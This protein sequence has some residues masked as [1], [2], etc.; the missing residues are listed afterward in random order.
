MAKKLLKYIFNGKK[1]D[2]FK[3]L[4]I[5]EYTFNMENPREYDSLIVKNEDKKFDVGLEPGGH[6]MPGCWYDAVIQETENN[7]IIAGIIT[8]SNPMKWY[9]WFWF[10]PIWIIFFIP[11]VVIR[12]I[13]GGWF[14]KRKIEARLD[15]F[16]TKYLNCEI[17]ENKR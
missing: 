1:E 10:I 15:L 7:V 3:K 9:D 16:M 2:F 14:Y 11:I 13:F 6:G 17:V 8:D 5:A 12:T 4:D